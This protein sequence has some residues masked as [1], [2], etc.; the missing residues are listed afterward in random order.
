ME[1][2]LQSRSHLCDDKERR[3][4]VMFGEQVAPWVA[5]YGERR[6]RLRLKKRRLPVPFRSALEVLLDGD[7]Y[8]EVTED[9]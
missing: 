6:E 5:A 8:P 3:G 1:T 2:T 9:N 7:N 4:R